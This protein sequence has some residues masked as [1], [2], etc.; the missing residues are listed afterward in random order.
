LNL[1]LTCTHTIYH[2]N[3]ILNVYHSFYD[4]C[5]ILLIRTDKGHI[6][7]TFIKFA[8]S[9][10]M[11]QVSP[12]RASKLSGWLDLKNVHIHSWQWLDL[13]YH[14]INIKSAGKKL[15]LI[16]GV[17]TGFT[18]IK[19]FEYEVYT[20]TPNLSNQNTV[21]TNVYKPRTQKVLW[22]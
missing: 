11:F 12:S 17:A 1:P 22:L 15:K 6:T 13:V 9:F 3:N 21:Y 14:N 20:H 2:K 7:S 18:V 4:N 10:T 8:Y 16:K 19:L 5:E